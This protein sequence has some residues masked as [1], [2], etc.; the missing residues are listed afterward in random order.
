MQAVVTRFLHY[1]TFD[2]HSSPTNKESPSTSSQ[3]IFADELVKELHHLG[4]RDIHRSETGTVYARLPGNRDVPAIGFIAHMDTS[5]DAPSANIHPR[6]VHYQ[7]GDIVLNESGVILS[8]DAFP[9][10]K[11]KVDEH[12]IVTDGTTLLGADDKAGIAEIMTMLE[13]LN[14]DPSIPHGPIYVAFTPDEEVGRGVEHF[15][16]DRFPVTFAF[17]VDGGQVHDV[18]WENFNAASAVVSIRGLGIHPGAAKGKMVNAL[19]LATEYDRLLPMNERPEHT[20]GYEG[21]YHLH[22]LHGDV[23]HATMEYLLRHHDEKEFSRMKQQLTRA[24]TYLNERQHGAWITVHITDSYQ[25][26]R[27]VMEQHPEII[28]LAYQAIRSLGLTPSSMPIRGGTDG[29]M[30]TAQGLPC[31]NLGTGGYNAHSRY[32]FAS[33]E[34]MELAVQLLVAISSYH[35]IH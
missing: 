10:L 7:G 23:E 5:P 24:A 9:V 21:F 12:L 11:Q 26:M 20:S 32:E 33:I 15:E 22:T 34:E 35:A 31:P 30:L 13:I 4:M 18:E 2:T 29:A 25:N 6:I 16:L 1:I 28:N 19:M 3:L 14:Q 17:T 27:K 8:P